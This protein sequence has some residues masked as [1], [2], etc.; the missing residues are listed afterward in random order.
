MY[1][2]TGISDLILA[3][4]IGT[5]RSGRATRKLQL[6]NW[7]DANIGVDKL[8]LVTFWGENAVSVY[9]TA[10][11][12]RQFAHD[13]LNTLPVDNADDDADYVKN[14]LANQAVMEV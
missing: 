3:E 11:Q 2:L 6:Q 4:I 9:V 14:R 1:D 7:C 8:E 13:I 10:I 12:L 5:S